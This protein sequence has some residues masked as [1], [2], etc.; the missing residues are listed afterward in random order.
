VSDRRLSWDGKLVEDDST[1]AGLLVC[2][3]ARFAFGFTGLAKWGG[4]ITQKWLLEA[5][6]DVAPPDFSAGELLQRLCISAS[7]T[8]ASHPALRNAPPEYKRLSIMF[9]GYLD[10]H[11]PP[12]L[13]YAILTNYQDRDAHVD[14][15]AALPEFRGYTWDE[16]RPA[17][18]E[19]TFVQRIGNWQAMQKSDEEELRHLLQFRKPLNAVRDKAVSIIKR[20]S[21]RP[22][23]RGTIGKW[24][25]SIVLYRDPEVDIASGYHPDEVTYHSRIIDK[26]VVGPQGSAAFRDVTIRMIEPGAS[27]PMLV[28]KVGRNDPCPCG[29][30]QKYKNCHGR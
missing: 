14:H 19:I 12:L 21:D 27:P 17:S 8:F 24:V 6:L 26:V 29:N 10:D 30:G 4:F 15:G 25:S 11:V 9:S 1:K 28:P 22:A 16:L 5:L 3:N 2:S 18:E 20:M 23:A 13:A 7:E